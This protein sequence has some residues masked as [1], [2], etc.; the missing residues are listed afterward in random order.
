MILGAKPIAEPFTFVS[1]ICTVIYFGYFII[2]MI[3]GWISVRVGRSGIKDSGS[4][5]LIALSGLLCS[6]SYGPCLLCFFVSPM[7]YHGSILW[8]VLLRS[9]Y[10]F[11]SRYPLAKPGPREKARSALLGSASVLRLVTS[12]VPAFSRYS[13]RARAEPLRSSRLYHATLAWLR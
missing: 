10:S 7:V 8:I 9:A 4:L 13:P 12:F 2:L 3:L 5:I 1:Q 6:A 11:A